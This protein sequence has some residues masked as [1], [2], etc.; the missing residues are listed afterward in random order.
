M[1][2]LQLDVSRHYA[3]DVKRALAR[4]MGDLYARIMQTTPEM[5]SVAIRELPEGSLWSCRDGEP[6]PG[7]VLVCDIRRGRTP[8]QRA[9]LAQALI[10]ACVEAL[11]LRSD[12]LPVEFTQHAGDEMFRAGRGWAADWTAGEAR[13][14]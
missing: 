4:R 14:K 11:E 2:Y 1:P 10:D 12:R 8:L 13:K 7:A 6:E 9:E 5:V 3:T